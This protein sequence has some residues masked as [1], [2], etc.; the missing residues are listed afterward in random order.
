MKCNFRVKYMV[1]CVG[2][3]YVSSTGKHVVLPLFTS[4]V[5]IMNDVL[6]RWRFLTSHKD[7]L[8][9]LRASCHSTVR[10]QAC[11]HGAKLMEVKLYDFARFL[12]RS[13]PIAVM[14]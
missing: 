10:P 3:S 4:H 13:S 7:V 6:G 2:W 12:S 11:V 8:K 1:M 5:I 9:L 14:T